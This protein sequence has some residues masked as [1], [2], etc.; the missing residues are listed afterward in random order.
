MRMIWIN[1]NKK[2]NLNNL[3]NIRFIISK[4]EY[5]KD[6]CRPKITITGKLVNDSQ[7][8]IY[9]VYLVSNSHEAIR[10]HLMIDST[11]EQR[12]IYTQ[13]GRSDFFKYI[14]DF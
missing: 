6:G 1:K 4:L 5:V 2:S 9:Y 10:H 8:V 13:I 7:L 3:I 12:Y 11:F 14:Q